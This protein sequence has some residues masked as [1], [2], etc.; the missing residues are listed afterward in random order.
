MLLNRRNLLPGPCKRR[1]AASLPRLAPARPSRRAGATV[2][3]ARL[4]AKGRQHSADQITV[5]K[6]LGEGSYG[7]VFEVSPWVL[8]FVPSSEL[9]SV[10]KNSVLRQRMSAGPA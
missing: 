5:K 6:V 10:A 7:Q 1:L 4:V 3:H 8:R 9:Q 2:V